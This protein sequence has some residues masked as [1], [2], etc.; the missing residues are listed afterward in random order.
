MIPY[1]DIPP[2]RLG[3]VLTFQ[4][5]GVLVATGCVVGYLVGRWHAKSVGL[6]LTNFRRL[7]CW[8]LVP[9]FLVAHWVSMLLYFPAHVWHNPASL[10]TINASLSSYGGFLGAVLGAFGYWQLYGKKVHL[11]LG[12]TA[13]AAVIGWLAGWFFGRLGCTVAHD[14]PGIP[15]DF[16]LAVNYPDGLRHD[17]GFYEWLYTIGLNIFI[18][19]MRRRS[20]PPGTIVGLVSV[21]YAPVRFF[22]DFL[23]VVDKRYLGLTPGQ[24]FSIVLLFVGIWIL[25][26]ARKRPAVLA[27]ASATQ[28]KGTPR[29]RQR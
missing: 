16:I 10:L 24:Y 29:A 11:P 14:H 26:T 3:N 4:P 21:Y 18:L 13:D 20:L 7:V 27:G 19:S 5:F 12:P 17:L 1:I 8:M 6:D 2:I 23:R 28:R 25:A 15:S 22:L 9:A